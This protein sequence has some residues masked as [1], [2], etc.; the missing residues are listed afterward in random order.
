MVGTCPSAG[1]HF[2]DLFPSSNTPSPALL[3][4]R[5]GAD[6]TKTGDRVAAAPTRVRWKAVDLAEE[7][8]VLGLQELHFPATA[9][10]AGSVLASP[11]PPPAPESWRMTTEVSALDSYARRPP[12]WPASRGARTC[13]RPS[14][15]STRRPH[16][17]P[18]SS[19]FQVKGADLVIDMLSVAASR[20]RSEQGR[21]LFY[22]IHRNTTAT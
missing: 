20:R 2:V 1:H 22:E 17:L 4:L 5:G 21:A 18:G 7:Q 19:P 15:R 9:V 8:R 14:A 13:C 10:M 6:R 12:R 16:P 3:S 11:P